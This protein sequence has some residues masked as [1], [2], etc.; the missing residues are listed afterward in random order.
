MGEYVPLIIYSPR[1]K[2]KVLI[3]DEVCQMDI[4]PTLLHI[5]D[6][7]AYCW[8]GFGVNLLEQDAWK[9]RPISPKEAQRLSDKMLRAN[10]F[11]NVITQVKKK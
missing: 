6:C 5:L 8:K 4:Y 1:I 9:N 10:F 3:N 2:Q 11:K 7:E